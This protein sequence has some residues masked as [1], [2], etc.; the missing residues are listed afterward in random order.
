MG[1]KLK[2]EEVHFVGAPKRLDKEG[3]SSFALQDKNAP[4]SPKIALRRKEK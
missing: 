2:F 4:P 1:L 3:N